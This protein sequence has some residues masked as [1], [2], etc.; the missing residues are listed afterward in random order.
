M[1]W[2]RCCWV[3][4]QTTWTFCFKKKNCHHLLLRLYLIVFYNWNHPVPGLSLLL[5]GRAYGFPSVAYA[6]VFRQK[7]ETEERRLIV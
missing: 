3:R 5:I 7:K 6:S 1:A 2:I 4:V